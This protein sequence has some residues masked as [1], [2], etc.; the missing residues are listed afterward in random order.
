MVKPGKNQEGWWTNAL[1]VAQ[2]VLVM[3][4]AEKLHPGCIL[5]F[6]FDNSANHHAKEPNGLNIDCSR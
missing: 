1:L 6:L 2:L 3:S 4:E 5:V